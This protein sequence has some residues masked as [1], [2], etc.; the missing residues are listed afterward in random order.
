M[1]DMVHL[2]IMD[3]S[4]YLLIL[5]W[6]SLTTCSHGKFTNRKEIIFKEKGMAH[7][8]MIKAAIDAK[9]NTNGRQAISG[10]ILN[11]ILHG[12]LDAIDVALA[13]EVQ[14]ILGDVPVEFDTL[15]EIA[16]YIATDK[17][18]YAEVSEVLNTIKTSLTTKVDKTTFNST[19]AGLT[20]SIAT[21][22]DKSVHESY[23]TKTDKAISQKVDK[24][25]YGVTIDN[26]NGQFLALSLTIQTL[27]N[28]IAELNKR[29][30]ALEG[31]K[32]SNLVGSAKVGY[33]LVG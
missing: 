8:D 2:P 11:N 32:T 3:K 24:T 18:Q 22:L 21:K 27:S 25:T 17:K 13:D 14:K 10:H 30:A 31:N 20:Q 4:P 5:G 7:F 26:I 19:I 29:V 6:V 16:D 1:Q 28:E 12:M 15:K 23:A 33:A 9:V